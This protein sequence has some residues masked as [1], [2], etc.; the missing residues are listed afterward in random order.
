M[1]VHMKNYQ[2]TP[3]QRRIAMAANKQQFQQSRK[4]KQFMYNHM[5]WNAKDL[6][7]AK[8]APWNWGI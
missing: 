7:W 8:Q 6:L 2:Q 1:V 5:G 3:R 4:Q